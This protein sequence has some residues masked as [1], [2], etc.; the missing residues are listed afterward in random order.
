MT[1][2]PREN[3]VKFCP[4]ALSRL[5]DIPVQRILENRRLDVENVGKMAKHRDPS[6]KFWKKLIGSS[7][8]HRANQLLNFFNLG[9][10]IRGRHG[11]LFFR[12][13]L[14]IGPKPATIFIDNAH[15]TPPIGSHPG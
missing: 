5:R 13:R 2:E 11:D 4:Y 14:H 12:V 9:G 6:A 3:H 1:L 8:Y 15:Q 10:E 7:L